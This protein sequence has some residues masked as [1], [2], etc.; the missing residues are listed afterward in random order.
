M[1]YFYDEELPAGFQDADFEMREMEASA[2]AMHRAEKVHGV[3]FHN[4][5]VGLGGDGKA[6]YPEAEGLIGDQR[7]CTDKCGR[8]FD[9]D[10]D[11]HDEHADLMAEWT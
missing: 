1:S 5:T 6:H 8:V 4:S 11:Y 9:S 3:C 10:Q 7:R 2:N